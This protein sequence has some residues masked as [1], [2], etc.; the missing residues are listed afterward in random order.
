MRTEVSQSLATAQTVE[1]LA[2]RLKTQEQHIYDVLSDSADI[3]AKLKSSEELYVNAKLTYT[4][5]IRCG[6]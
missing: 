1:E 3:A 6:E 2:E 4:C 5:L